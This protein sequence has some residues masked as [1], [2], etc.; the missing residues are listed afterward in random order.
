ML[1]HQN[2]QQQHNNDVFEIDN[3]QLNLNNLQEQDRLRLQNGFV[4]TDA[5]DTR[6][7]VAAHKDDWKKLPKALSAEEKVQLKTTNNE[8]VNKLS[9][10]TTTETQ[11]ALSFEERNKTRRSVIEN[12]TQLLDQD[13]KWYSKDSKSMQQVKEKVNTIYNLMKAELPKR[14]GGELGV[15]PSAVKEQYSKAY[16]DAIKACNDYIDSHKNPWFAAGIRR[17]QKVMALYENLREEKALI[18]QAT[19]MMKSGA[20]AE[21]I[22]DIKT[23]SDLL[24]QMH[25]IKISESK[26]EREGN[27]TTVY[28]LKDKDGNEYYMKENLPLISNELGSYLDRRI[29]QVKSNIGSDSKE[30]RLEKLSDEELNKDMDVMQYMLKKLTV[31]ANGSG[32]AKVTQSDK[33]ATEKRYLK[34]LGHDFNKFYERLSEYNEFVRFSKSVKIRLQE[35]ASGGGAIDSAMIDETK[36]KLRSLESAAKRDDG[37]IAYVKMLLRTMENPQNAPAAG[38]QVAIEEKADKKFDD[39][40]EYTEKDWLLKNVTNLGLDKKKDAGLINKLV[41]L[42]DDQEDKKL[43]LRRLLLRTMGKDAE[44][45]GQM[46]ENSGV[47]NKGDNEEVVVATNN[48]A[49]WRIAKQFGFQDVITSSQSSVV[50]MKLAGS[51][52]EED[53][54]CTLMSVAPGLEM[55]KLVEVAQKTGRKLQYSPNAVRQ[56]TRLQMLDTVCL[57]TDRHWRNFKCKTEPDLSDLVDEDFNVPYVMAQLNKKNIDTIKIVSIMSYDHDQAFSKDKGIEKKDFEQTGADGKKIAKKNGFLPPIFTNIEENSTQFE[58]LDDKSGT[59]PVRKKYIPKK[60]DEALIEKAGKPVIRDKYK[61]EHEWKCKFGLYN[62]TTNEDDPNPF[63]DSNIYSKFLDELANKTDEYKTLFKMAAGITTDEKDKIDSC[64]DTFKNYRESENVDLRT[65]AFLA[66]QD[67]KVIYDRCV[68]KDPN[69]FVK[70]DSNIKSRE[71]RIDRRV[72]TAL[73]QPT[74]NEIIKNPNNIMDPGK[75]MMEGL[76]G[77]EFDFKMQMIFYRTSSFIK[78]DLQAQK[79]LRNKIRLR[80]GKEPTLDE[81]EFE[82]AEDKR[83][84]EI[85]KKRA[86]LKGDVPTLL[87]MDRAA[88]ESIKNMK[89]TWETQKA[90]LLDLKWDTER[91]D[92][93]KKRIDSYLD[94][95]EQARK[96]AEPWLKDRYKNANDPRAKFFLDEKDYD[97]FED[98]TEFAWDPGMSYLCNE[99]EN[100][101]LAEEDYSKRFSSEQQKAIVDKVNKQRKNSPRLH[102]IAPEEEAK[103]EGGKWTKPKYKSLINGKLAK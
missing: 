67:L 99:D 21:Q 56:L 6:S 84:A 98:I 97:K 45:Y 29:K 17:K 23:G 19:E 60:L 43:G 68:A 89:A 74:Q 2:L 71:Y 46:T 33:I 42:C 12:Q 47:I 20:F 30:Q 28:R 36:K 69:A 26:M 10:K 72:L 14:K 59:K 3:E 50:K 91:I 63:D 32:D 11:V 73:K 49:T 75:V 37:A 31:N 94:Q 15:N 82:A 52:K 102:D 64:F 9:I 38:G 25:S 1:P 4:P 79:V 92:A 80:E 62:F 39:L 101:L 54:N 35:A 57:Q 100:Y 51:E 65:D 87:H 55:L 81:K 48:T 24:L 86:R 85:N 66:L 77:G 61:K 34:F 90:I 13:S 7:I 96:I 95:I 58:Y 22:N 16:D 70:V 41:E 53:V 93:M 83:I 88:Y 5:K 44:L 8:L 18:I 27:T 40:K 76:Q 78:N 103:K